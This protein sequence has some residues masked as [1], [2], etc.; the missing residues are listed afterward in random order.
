MLIECGLGLWPLALLHLVAHSFYKAH[1]FLSA[2]SAVDAWRL[3]AMA[4]RTQPTP[5]R[6]ALA[7]VTT[8]AAAVVTC[9]TAELRLEPSVLTLVVAWSAVPWL[10]RP[11]TLSTVARAVLV[12][13][14]YAALHFL[15]SLYPVPEAQGSLL[16]PLTAVVGFALLLSVETILELR[17][18]GSFAGRLHTWLFAGFYLDERFTR[19]TFRLWPPQLPKAPIRTLPEAMEI[20]RRVHRR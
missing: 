10:A 18:H 16:A 9:L 2:G 12:P 19:L 17:P 15:F 20:S 13:V 3:D 8:T 4:R 7:I 11:L 1:A 5:V 14:F 6:W